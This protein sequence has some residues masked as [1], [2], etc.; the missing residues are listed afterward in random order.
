MTPLNCALKLN[1]VLHRF[2]QLERRSTTFALYQVPGKEHYKSL[3]G[4]MYLESESVRIHRS[5]QLYDVLVNEVGSNAER[6]GKVLRQE[7]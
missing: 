6:T 2:Q 4:L 7:P 1:N 3:V 5:T